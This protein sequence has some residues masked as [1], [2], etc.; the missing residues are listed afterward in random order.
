MLVEKLIVGPLVAFKFWQVVSVCTKVL[1]VQVEWAFTL[2]SLVIVQAK[3][4]MAR[5][6]V[7]VKDEEI[8]D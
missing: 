5:F 3:P 7:C 6:L 8:C 2:S 4:S 1:Q